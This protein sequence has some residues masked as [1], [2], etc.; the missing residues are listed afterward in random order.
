MKKINQTS[1]KEEKISSKI[2][3]MAETEISYNLCGKVR[4][5]DIKYLLMTV[6]N[7][8]CDILNTI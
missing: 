5:E 3:K 4:V 7:N 6:T 1:I 2:Q 8:D